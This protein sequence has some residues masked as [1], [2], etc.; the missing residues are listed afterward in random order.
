MTRFW[1]AYT[2]EEINAEDLMADGAED[3]DKQEEKAIAMP[4][5]EQTISQNIRKANRQIKSELEDMAKKVKMFRS[6]QMKIRK[7]MPAQLA[8]TRMDN[9][10]NGYL[11]LRD[12]HLSFA[13]LFDLAIKNEE[14]RTLFNEID[15]N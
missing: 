14:I 1:A 7:T 5:L 12:F 15:S 8:F 6:I 9:L 13:R 3:E 2:Y 4:I 10:N 11:S